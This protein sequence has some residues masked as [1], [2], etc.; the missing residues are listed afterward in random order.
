MVNLATLADRKILDL[1]GPPG[2]VIND[3]LEVLH[4]RGRIGPYLEPPPGAPSFNL[5]RLAR[6]EI[7][8]ELR[9]A[10]HEAQA[11][12][13]RVAVECTLNDAETTR[14]FKLEVVPIGHA[15]TSG[16]L[17]LVLFHQPVTPKELPDAAQKAPGETASVDS[18]RL[19][20]LERELMVTREYLQSTIEELETSS[21]ELQSS[22]EELQSSNE[23]LQS[24]NEEL[25]TSKEE[26]QSS[27]EE[28]TTVNDELQNRM[29][30]LQ[31]ANDDLHNMLSSIRNAA[32]IVGMDLRIRRYTQTA[33]RLLNLVPG[34][35]GRSVSLLN[36]FVLGLRV[37]EM[38]AK[39]IEDL[40]PIETE[41]LCTDQLWYKLHVLPY[42]TLDHSIK[43]AMIV[44][45]DIDVRKRTIDLSRDVA[46]YAS[47]FLSI[48]KQ[49]LIIIDRGLHVLWRNDRFQ[50]A[51]PSL[52]A[53]IDGSTERTLGTG[54][55]DPALMSRIDDALTTGAPFRDVKTRFALS[56]TGE[57]TFKVSGSRFPSTRNE[58][59]V[60]L[61][62]E[63]DIAPGA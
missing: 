2:V 57:K 12:N 26:L 18:Q 25:E 60:M 5:L 23:E 37:E 50:A 35:I 30:E 16:R 61:S 6:P 54:Q 39:V 27:N 28:L 3:D 34:D 7:H 42:R 31:Q 48:I 52:S 45:V 33:E 19:Q 21:E 29:S 55:W 1:Y 24:T 36:A 62:F 53:A 63:E 44:L 14:R 56:D 32:V 47:R 46:E 59:A 15:E 13:T 11:K 10:I 20:V 38:A 43:G 9:R 41:V 58:A 8:V 40:A 22:N 17:M 49:P 4:I 51:F